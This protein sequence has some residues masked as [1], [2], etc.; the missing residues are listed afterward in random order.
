MTLDKQKE[1]IYE[2]ARTI[3]TKLAFTDGMEAWMPVLYS[4]LVELDELDERDLWRAIDRANQ[5]KEDAP[6][7]LTGILKG[8]LPTGR[9]SQG[10]ACHLFASHNLEWVVGDIPPPPIRK[11]ER[12]DPYAREG[13]ITRMRHAG[14]T[15]EEINDTLRNN[16]M[17]ELYVP[18]PR[19]K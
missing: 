15:S 10:T 2:R 14:K 9:I 7:Y 4:L 16:G 3:T 18:P 5:K 11:H 13:I 1:R 17:E 12:A 8:K 19:E 6:R